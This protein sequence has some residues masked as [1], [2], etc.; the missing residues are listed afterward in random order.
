M[1]TDRPNLSAITV[2][3][4]E[5]DAVDVAAVRRALKGLGFSGNLQVARS[6]DEA[7]RTLRAPD[8]PVDLVLLDLNMPVRSGHE[9]LEDVHAMEDDSLPPIVVL[10]SSSDERDLQRCFAA[11]AAGYFVK[12]LEQSRLEGTLRTILGYWHSSMRPPHRSAPPRGGA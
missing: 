12:S 4:V 1:S 7:T 2:L 11:C 9:L 6:V 10:S 3:L 5:D 8:Q